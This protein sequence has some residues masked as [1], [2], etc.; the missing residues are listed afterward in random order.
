[1]D[2]L[3]ERVVESGPAWFVWIAPARGMNYQQRHMQ[4]VQRVNERLEPD[5]SLWFFHLPLVV[6]SDKAEEAQM[7][8]L[9]QQNICC[10]C[11]IA[12]VDQSDVNL[13]EQ[14]SYSAKETAMLSESDSLQ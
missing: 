14:M 2:V 13:N 6:Q 1:M 11:K 12:S 3:A 8:H 9:L 5:L 4:V 10:F 7:P